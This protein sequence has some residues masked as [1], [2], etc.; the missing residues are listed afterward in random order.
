MEQMQYFARSADGTGLMV[1]ESGKGRPIVVVHGGMGAAEHWD[2]V[3]VLLAPSW[4]VLGLE[5]RLYGRSGPPQSAHSMA[6]EAEDITAVLDT[7]GEPAIVVGHS[8]G[9]VATLEAA[10]LHPAN[11]AGLVL[12]EPPVHAG[13][14][15]G[16]E[17]QAR[18]EA[19]LAAGDADTAL[20]IFF[21]DIVGFDDALIDPMRSPKWR[22]GWEYMQTVL[23]AQME[24]NRAI[25][26]LPFG[27]DRYATIDVPALLLRG[28]D[29][30]QHLQDR[31]AAL[32]DVLPDKRIVDLP[33]EGHNANMSSPQ[34]VAD[35][36]AGFAGK[37]FG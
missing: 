6:R 15:L 4:C 35:A 20:Y 25:R 16:G 29:S 11:L 12:Y 8:S 10:L 36:I 33:G 22:A 2:P 3:N 30:P 23:P 27:V 37:V 9:A 34:L 24:D 5:R 32:A 7:I 26:A 28:T 14:P 18:A 21:H 31:L 19:A 17:H 13:T 1:R